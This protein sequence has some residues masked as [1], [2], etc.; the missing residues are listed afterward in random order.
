MQGVEHEAGYDSMMTAQVFIKLSSQLRQGG[1][2]KYFGTAPLTPQPDVQSGADSDAAKDAD[3]DSLRTI[4]DLL[5]LGKTN[6]TFVT[7]I[8]AVVSAKTIAMVDSGELIPRL[9]AEFWKIY[10]NRL[11]VFGTQERMCTIG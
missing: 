3:A 9:G 10:G 1:T 6:D 8:P 5:H 11:R 7:S 4:F 2:S